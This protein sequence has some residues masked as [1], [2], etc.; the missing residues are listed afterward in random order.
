MSLKR[1]RINEG[2]NLLESFGALYRQST[3]RTME[4][5]RLQ[6]YGRGHRGV[7]HS[8]DG[9]GHT[10]TR[11]VQP[12][13]RLVI[14]FSM[15]YF[16]I[17][18][19]VPPHHYLRL[20]QDLITK[21][22]ERVRRVSQ[23]FFEPVKSLPLFCETLV[24]EYT[25]SAVEEALQEMEE[26]AAVREQLGEHIVEEY[27]ST[28]SIFTAIRESRQGNG[29]YYYRDENEE[30]ENDKEGGGDLDGH[31]LV[32]AGMLLMR[33][34]DSFVT[35]LGSLYQQLAFFTHIRVFVLALSR[36][37]ITGL[38]R[39]G[40]L[41][42]ALPSRGEPSSHPE[43]GRGSRSG[44]VYQASS[45]DGLHFQ[46]RYE[47]EM[48]MLLIEGAGGGKT[49][50]FSAAEEQGTSS[51]GGS[52][53]STGVV[54]QAVSRNYKNGNGEVKMEQEDDEDRMEGNEFGQTPVTNRSTSWSRSGSR[55]LS[56]TNNVILGTRGS[57]SSEKSHSA[58]NDIVPLGSIEIENDNMENMEG[59]PEG[60]EE[61]E[62]I[63]EGEAEEDRTG[64]VKRN[65]KRVEFS[66]MKGE[67][68]EEEEE[69]KERMK[70]GL[71][72]DK[73]KERRP[74]GN[75]PPEG[76]RLS[77]ALRQATATALL[78]DLLALSHVPNGVHQTD[79]KE[80]EKE[81]VVVASRGSLHDKMERIHEEEKKVE[82]VP[83][84][85]S[86]SSQGHR[87]PGAVSLSREAKDKIRGISPSFYS[88][89]HS[90]L[91]VMV[92]RQ[93][94]HQFALEN[95]TRKAPDITPAQKEV[96]AA[97]A[98]ARRQQILL[99]GVRYGGSA[100]RYGGVAVDYVPDQAY[101]QRLLGAAYGDEVPVNHV[102]G[103]GGE[104]G[105]GR[106]DGLATAAPIVRGLGED[107]EIFTGEVLDYYL[108]RR[109]L[110][111]IQDKEAL[112]QQREG[113][114]T[115]WNNN[116]NNHSNSTPQRFQKD[117]REVSSATGLIKP[118][119]VCKVKT[120]YTWTQYNRTHYDS[121]TNPPPKSVMW[122]DFTLYYPALAN[123]KR[124]P[125]TFFRVEDT[126][127]GPTDE[128]CLLV[129][130]VGPPYADVAYRIERKQW[131]PRR[132][133]VRISFDANGKF[134]LFFRFSNSNYRR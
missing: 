97:E 82:A 18:D 58:M 24:E 95:A 127:K 84:S 113:T 53:T 126:P 111:S 125:L 14:V 3:S 29:G 12:V 86:A 102:P 28:Q 105:A 57:S 85:S 77:L 129:F 4:R 74:T 1:Q 132:G 120:G 69:E 122:Y 80:E 7:P 87:T 70:V 76:N 68:G 25:S 104:P 48:L 23:S 5:L 92:S 26:I 93:Q 56:N 62:D 49:R 72:Q 59:V 108:R 39:G 109:P 83:S 10:F 89:L 90:R 101:Y 71:K 114:R 36:E 38:G 54:S 11:T 121:R 2:L 94:L 17:D 99:H 79:S 117:N 21:S 78:A 27:G 115:Q 55:S 16:H 51:H 44:S 75:C 73:E 130:S 96:L 106:N 67:E 118:D 43:G 60:K 110:A 61:E 42:S 134:R 116:N 46:P 45:N 40:R 133:G 65:R 31:S 34:Q 88:M 41:P 37:A 103:D 6:L 22:E 131:D 63:E 47:R 128:Y 33:D 9:G 8:K 64:N 98:E 66:I 119:R 35:L 30:D 32:H 123:T 52:S 124:S 19:L 91:S 100:G 107:E 20:A 15:Y 13:D 50:L 81:K 112:R